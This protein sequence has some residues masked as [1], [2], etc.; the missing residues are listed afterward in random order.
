MADREVF[1]HI[2][3]DLF[4]VL[5]EIRR[6]E[7]IFHT[8]QSG[9]TLDEFERATAPTYWEVGASGR[10]YSRGFILRMLAQQPPVDAGSLGWRRYDD[11]LRRLG[12][13]TYLFTYTLRQGERITRRATIWQ[14]SPEGWRIL[15]HQGTI[16]SVEEDDTV[17]A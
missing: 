6:R 13:D 1:T 14:R 10:R 9:S 11:A 3:P 8:A 7:P 5:E 15:Y 12:P 16:V 17:P 2:D 4:P